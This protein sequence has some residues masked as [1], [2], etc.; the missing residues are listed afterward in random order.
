MTP[1]AAQKILQVNRESYMRIAREFDKTRSASWEDFNIFTPF[2][3]DSMKVLDIGCGNGRVYTALN[4]YHVSYTGIDQNTY[5]IE[6]ARTRYPDARFLVGDILRFGGIT[7]LTGEK[8]DSIFCIA[9]FSHMPTREMRLQT[10]TQIRSFLKPGG[11]LLMLNWNLWRVDRK[12]K[13]IWTCTI[14]RITLTTHEW[15][16]RYQISERDLDFRDVMTLWGHRHNPS[17]LYYRAYSSGELNKLCRDAGFGDVQSLYT[18]RGKKA[19]WWDGRNIATIA[20]NTLLAAPIVEEREKK[21]IKVPL[22]ASYARG[23]WPV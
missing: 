16:F 19:H 5:L 23:G 20:H 6:Q 21:H 10:L 3:K 14:P 13:N 1:E 2:V 17:P 15:A 8:F 12:H 18:G 11:V 7:E 9:V 4:P 22:G